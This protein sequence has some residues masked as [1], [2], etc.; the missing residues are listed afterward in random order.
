MALNSSSPHS[1]IG[2]RC[3]PFTVRSGAV[4]HTRN[5]TPPHASDFGLLK[6]MT[7]LPFV[8]SRQLIVCTTGF[9]VGPTEPRG[10]ASRS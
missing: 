5:D 10:P 1:M 6:D 9:F 8:P 4:L 3:I 2:T 7:Q